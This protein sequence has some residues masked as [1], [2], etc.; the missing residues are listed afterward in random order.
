MR[1]QRPVRNAHTLVEMLVVAAMSVLIMYLIAWCFQQ[2]LGSFSNAKSQVDLMDRQAI[3][4]TVLARDLEAEH[5]LSED[6][7]PD[8]VKV[9][10]Q[11]LDKLY[12]SGGTAYGYTPPRAGY[13]S[14]RS[15]P[16]GNGNNFSEGFDGNGFTSSRSSDHFLAFTMILKGGPGHHTFDAEVPYGSKYRYV[17]RAGEV[18]YFL[19]D[20]GDR[21]PG[22]YPLYTLKRRQRL[23]ALTDDDAPAY[24]SAVASSD[25]VEVM[26]TNGGKM[27]TLR[28]LTIPTTFPNSVRLVPF[29]PLT[30][31]SVRYG[32]DTLLSN[33][34]SFEMKF[35]GPTANAY[36]PSDPKS[37]LWPRPVYSPTGGQSNPDTPYD[38]LPFDGNFDTFSTLPNKWY[39]AKNVAV[40]AATQSSPMKP[41]RI[42]G[43]MIRLRSYDPN[44]RSTRQ[45]TRSFSL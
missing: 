22:G 36:W 8:S 31:D 39:D 38:N 19:V 29:A 33:V 28:D 13:F 16:V 25:S 18:A 3:V 17:G 30:T 23:V 5:F 4:M 24:N 35:T 41:L 12:T 9:S 32:D 26:V 2:G 40:D 1:Y 34:I 44:T 14:A 15:L 11:R 42:T 20:T 6:G 10:G 45:T 21:T 27:R 37:K 7:K 43:V